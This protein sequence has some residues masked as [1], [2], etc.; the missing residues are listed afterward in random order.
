MCFNDNWVFRSAY[1]A[2]LGQVHSFGTY[3]AKHKA[4]KLASNATVKHCEL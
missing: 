1:L 4:E 2:S 3:L